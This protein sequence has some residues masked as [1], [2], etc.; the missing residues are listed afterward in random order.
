MGSDKIIAGFKVASKVAKE[1]KETFPQTTNGVDIRMKEQ[2]EKG[3]PNAKRNKIEKDIDMIEK[4]A[5]TAKKI[6]PH[7]TDMTDFVIGEYIGKLSPNAKKNNIKDYIDMAEKGVGIAEKILPN[8]LN[9]IDK[10]TASA[11]EKMAGVIV[12]T[13]KKELKETH[14]SKVKIGKFAG[15]RILYVGTQSCIVVDKESNELLYLTPETVK[16]CC[17]DKEKFKPHK[18]KKYYYY[19]ITFVEEISKNPVYV[20]VSGRNRRNLDSLAETLKSNHRFLS[21]SIEQWEKKSIQLFE[22]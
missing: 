17:F 14:G 1:I 10:N 22:D 11:M 19:E 6:L 7:A 5:G 8:V 15:C 20:R 2:I 9:G 4:G 3:S 16:S 13:I 21:N 12:E 18:M